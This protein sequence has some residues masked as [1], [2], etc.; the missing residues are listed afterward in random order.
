[1]PGRQGHA[2]LG[3]GSSCQAAREQCAPRVGFP[4]LASWG[5]MPLE[6]QDPS[7]LG[8]MPAHMLTLF[9]CN[10]VDEQTNAQSC[11]AHS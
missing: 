4:C 1:V 9:C 2:V 8:N 11:T 5:L 7:W 10:N 6:H 3:V